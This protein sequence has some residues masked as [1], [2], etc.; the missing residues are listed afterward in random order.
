[1]TQITL[2]NIQDSKDY[3]KYLFDIL[4]KNKEHPKEKLSKLQDILYILF[5]TPSLVKIREEEEI[6]LEEDISSRIDQDSRCFSKATFAIHK[7][8][9]E[10]NSSKWFQCLAEEADL[11]KNKKDVNGLMF[12]LINQSAVNYMKTGRISEAASDNFDFFIKNIKEKFMSPNSGTVRSALPTKEKSNE[13]ILS[14]MKIRFEVI[15][16]FYKKLLEIE[17]N[18]LSEIKNKGESLLFS[19]SVPEFKKSDMPIVNKTG[20]IKEKA[21]DPI[22]EFNKGNKALIKVLMKNCR[23]FLESESVNS[24]VKNHIELTFKLLETQDMSVRGPNILSIDSDIIKSIKQ[25]YFNLSLIKNKCRVLHF[26]RRYKKEVLGFSTRREYL[27][28]KYERNR[29]YFES[30]FLKMSQGEAIHKVNYKSNGITEHYYQIDEEQR[31]LRIYKNAAAQEKNESIF[32]SYSFNGGIDQ[33][34]FGLSTENLINKYKYLAKKGKAMPWRF[35]SFD[36]GNKTIDLYLSEESI[37]K[38][39]CALKYFIEERCLLT[40][41]PSALDYYFFKIKQRIL[42]KLKEFYEQS[43]DDPAIKNKHFFVVIEKIYQ[44]LMTNIGA[45][46]KLPIYKLICF[47]YKIKGDVPGLVVESIN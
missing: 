20:S 6:L 10:N 47:A 4:A 18:L 41:I 35:M 42:F 1:M 26:F 27:E 22:I 37:N 14:E 23:E 33:V 25:L 43:K 19:A 21:T 9:R 3:I 7:F 32:T 30:L 45:Y 29:C 36:L 39:Y 16:E 28:Q 13:K 24:T 15:M 38:W 17:E 2:N 44:Y 12:T 8:L 11:F 34:V 5:R 31:C 40:K 46:Q